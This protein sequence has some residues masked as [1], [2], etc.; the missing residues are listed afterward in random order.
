MESMKTEKC[1]YSVSNQFYYNSDN[2]CM[3]S[4]SLA[5]S[6][7]STV[8]WALFLDSF[9]TL[10]GAVVEFSVISSIPEAAAVGDSL[11]SGIEADCQEAVLKAFKVSSSIQ[12]MV[13]F[14]P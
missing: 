7:D 11:P 12:G 8:L 3:S 14:D 9:S 5:I 10:G 2:D 13:E 1:E 6:G 4:S